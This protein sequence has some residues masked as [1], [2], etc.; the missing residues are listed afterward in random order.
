MWADL[1]AFAETAR[2]AYRRNVWPTQS[3]YV[4]CWL[5]KDALS[6]IFQDALRP[7]GVT[8]NVGRGYDGWDS[9]HNGAERF[10]GTSKS[11]LA[12]VPYST[13]DCQQSRWGGMDF[14]AHQGEADRARELA[15]AAFRCLLNAG[16]DLCVI[17]ET[18]GSGGWHVWA[19]SPDFHDT[20]EWVRLLKS[21]VALIGAPIA[22]GVC[23]IFPPD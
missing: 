5:E 22:A 21:V 16:P 15:F 17:L 12:F 8:L 3:Q 11:K 6:G 14:D 10:A 9:I 4:E 20:R 7:Y 23:E 13:N 19:I 18:S 2:R 1:S